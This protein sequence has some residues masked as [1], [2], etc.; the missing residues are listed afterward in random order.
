MA[1]SAHPAQDREDMFRESS[2]R[3]SLSHYLEEWELPKQGK[4]ASR[5]N[6]VCKGPELNESKCLL[7]LAICF[8]GTRKMSE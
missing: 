4:N 5:G 8:M 2:Q 3:Y 7:G 6:S 1:L